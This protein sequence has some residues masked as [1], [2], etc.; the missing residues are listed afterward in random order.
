MWT[1]VTKAIIKNDQDGATDAKSKIE[2]AQREARAEREESG[3]EWEAKHFK[4]DAD[5]GNWTSIY[6]RSVFLLLL[7]LFLSVVWSAHL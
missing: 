3:L 6:T 1:D 2:L 4:F 7:L 5:T